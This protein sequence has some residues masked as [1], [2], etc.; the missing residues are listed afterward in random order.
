[1]LLYMLVYLPPFIT[2]HHP[3]DMFR[4]QIGFK[5]TFTVNLAEDA[6]D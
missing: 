2:P 6:D 3:V 1:M 4:E 5:K